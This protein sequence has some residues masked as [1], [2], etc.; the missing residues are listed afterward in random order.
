MVLA[1]TFFI[2]TRF[3]WKQLC[4]SELIELF[5]TGKMASHIICSDKILNT[6][7]L[8]YYHQLYS[9]HQQK[10]KTKQNRFQNNT[11]E[12]LK[13]CQIYTLFSTGQSIERIILP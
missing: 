7:I 12:Y 9:E 5:A 4:Y 8:H 13:H 1:E 6:A 11:Q 3:E 2:Y 10:N